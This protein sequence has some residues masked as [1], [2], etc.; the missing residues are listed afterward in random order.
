VAAGDYVALTVADT[1]RGL[2]PEVAAQAFEP[3]F[4]TKA[5]G[6][7]G[8]L[9]LATCFGIVTG[10]QGA[11][12]I[13]SEPGRGARFTVTLPRVQERGEGDVG[14]GQAAPEGVRPRRILL[15][16]DDPRVRRLIARLL[17]DSPHEVVA[18]RSPEHAL[19]LCQV[20]ETRPDLLLTDMVMPTMNGRELALAMSELIEGLCVLY[21]SG[22]TDG[23]L[24]ATDELGPNERFLPKPFSRDELLAALAF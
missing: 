9:G 20:P 19:E 15:V 23:K 11:I 12:S 4:T 21:V 7:P 2:T 8:G 17:A 22:Y 3:F 5:D 14:A 16:E 24:V 1:G 13:D 18:A 10:A 6:L